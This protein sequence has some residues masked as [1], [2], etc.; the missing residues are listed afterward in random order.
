MV[1]SRVQHLRRFHSTRVLHHRAPRGEEAA[2]C[3]RLFRSVDGARY[4][5]EL[6]DRPAIRWRLWNAVQESGGVRVFGAFEQLANRRLLNGLARV[7]HHHPVGN[8]GNDTL[9]AGHGNDRVDGANGDDLLYGGDGNDTIRG[10]KGRDR[11]SAGDGHDR[12]NGG[13]G[14]DLLLGGD[15]RDSIFGGSGNDVALGGDGDDYINGQGGSRDTIAGN[16]GADVLVGDPTEIDEQFQLT[17]SWIDS[18]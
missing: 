12:V 8:S 13:S 3:T 4:A 7:H 11:V 18:L 6:G 10:S 17:E 9:V 15:G 16:Q 14:D 5:T 1:I 2:F